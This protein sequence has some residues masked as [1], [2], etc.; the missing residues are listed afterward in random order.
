M[1]GNGEDWAK[2]DYEL[3]WIYHQSLKGSE[4]WGPL[5]VE[6]EPNDDHN[7]ANYLP[8]SFVYLASISTKNDVDYYTFTLTERQ[9]YTA[10]IVTGHDKSVLNAEVF[11]ADNKSMGKFKFYDDS[12]YFDATLPAGTY[13]IKVSVKD[14][15]IKWDNDI[16]S[17]RGWGR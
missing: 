11:D 5:F 10:F 7:H 17:I 3:Y 12:D 13:Y 16:Y 8:D 2:V 15:K 6:F 14:T 1:E 9:S 4:D